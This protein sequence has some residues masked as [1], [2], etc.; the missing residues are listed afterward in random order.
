MKTETILPD[1][2]HT[3]YLY[4]SYMLGPWKILRDTERLRDQ[5]FTEKKKSKGC[6]SLKMTLGSALTSRVTLGK[7]PNLSVPQ[8]PHL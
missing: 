6:E 3:L 7:S 1:S 2:P 8:I 4:A 5:A